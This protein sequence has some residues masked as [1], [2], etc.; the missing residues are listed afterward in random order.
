MLGVNA[1]ELDRSKKAVDKRDRYQ[2]TW[3]VLED[4]N[5]DPR[6]VSEAADVGSEVSL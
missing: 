3:S 6:Q 2:P 1:A 5:L 4:A